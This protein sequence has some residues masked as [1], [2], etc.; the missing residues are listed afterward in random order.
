MR[1]RIII[2]IIFQKS[3][4]QTIGPVIGNGRVSISPFCRPFSLSLPLSLHR[5][6]RHHRRGSKARDG[7]AYDRVAQASQH[8]AQRGPWNSNASGCVRCDSVSLVTL[9]QP[10]IYCRWLCADGSTRRRRWGLALG[11]SLGSRYRTVAIDW[12]GH[13]VLDISSIDGNTVLSLSLSFSYSRAPR[14]SISPRAGDSNGIWFHIHF[15]SLDTLIRSIGH[16]DVRFLARFYEVLFN[17]PFRTI[18]T[19]GPVIPFNGSYTVGCIIGSYFFRPRNRFL[20]IIITSDSVFRFLVVCSIINSCMRAC[21]CVHNRIADPS[22]DE[23]FIRVEN[24]RRR[25]HGATAVQL[26]KHTARRSGGPGYAP[27][28]GTWIETIEARYNGSDNGPAT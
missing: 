18:V 28:T 26:G 16:E 4:Q 5:V 22:R 2:T 10:E 24:R 21:A 8:N 6:S 9:M 17:F 20:E 27:L 13:A 25:S 23:R 12:R 11:C 15:S 7:G 19:R 14:L 1:Q 3:G